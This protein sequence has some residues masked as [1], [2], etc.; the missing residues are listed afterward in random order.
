MLERLGGRSGAFP[1]ASLLGNLRR[2]CLA[3]AV[4]G[5]GIGCIVWVRTVATSFER[6][7]IDSLGGTLRAELV[8]AST[9]IV[10]GWVPAP[11][12]HAV[13]DALS[14]VPGVLAVAGNR[15][16]DATYRDTSIAINAFD[17]LYFENP[18]F[19]QPGLVGEHT[20]SVWDDVANG[21]GVIVSTNFLLNF[22]ARVG[23]VIRLDSPTGG[24][25]V[26]IVGAT[27]A[28]VSPAGTVEMSRALYER[29]WNDRQVNRVWV[30]TERGADLRA[31]R[32]AIGREVGAKYGAQVF[33]SGEMLD[34]LASQA[35][36]AFA[37]IVV[38][39]AIVLLVAL[40][41]VGDALASG[42]IQRTREIGTMRAVG[43][44]SRDVARMVL[45][46]SMMLATLGLVLATATGLVLA[47][48]WVRATLPDLLGWLL[49]LYVPWP[50]LAMVAI[51]TFAVCLAA[52]ILPARAAARLEVKQALRYE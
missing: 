44:R 5:V 36:R 26:P 22:G 33:T 41:G 6:T 10:S 2:T 19:G 46:E 15:L 37:P 51:P 25:E 24:V 13:L 31:V 16:A 43:A 32:E 42:V 18:E 20:A 7:L 12:N 30:R 1:S 52:A 39:E 3:A 21:R 23:D 4:L 38:I 27:V 45:T 35:R 28:F 9:R 47:T 40:I 11:V 8:V 14:E 29:H 34:Y 50:R 17:P 48:L 49:Q